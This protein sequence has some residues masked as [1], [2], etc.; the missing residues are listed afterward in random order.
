MYDGSYNGNHPREFIFQY[1]IET[2]IWN[3]AQEINKMQM[4]KLYN[5]NSFTETTEAK[6]PKQLRN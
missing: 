6:V 3:D 5:Q 1:K 4:I 2:R